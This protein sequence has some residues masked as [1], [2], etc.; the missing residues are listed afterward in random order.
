MS[1]RVAPKPAGG[2]RPFRPGELV[3]AV[4]GGYFAGEQEIYFRTG[5][6]FSADDEVVRCLPGSFMPKDTVASEVVHWLHEPEPPPKHESDF[7]IREAEPIPVERQ[8]V[9]CNAVGTLSR[10]I[11][12]GQIVDISDPIVKAQPSCFTRYVP[13]SDEDVRAAQ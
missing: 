10:W 1:P 3:V 5:Q 4:E 9:C 2:R 6:T 12:V 13:L 7:N 8:V 11:T